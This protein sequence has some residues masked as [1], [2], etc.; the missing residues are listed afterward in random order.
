MTKLSELNEQQ[1]EDVLKVIADQMMNSALEFKETPDRTTFYEVQEFGITYVKA[2][3]YKKYDVDEL[4]HFCTIVNTVAEAEPLVFEDK[5]GRGVRNRL[6]EL[7]DILKKESER[8]CGLYKRT[9]PELSKKIKKELTR[10]YKKSYETQLGRKYDGYYSSADTEAQQMTVEFWKNHLLD[11]V[12]I[13]NDTPSNENLYPIMVCLPEYIDSFFTYISFVH[14]DIFI[15]TLQT[16]INIFGNY[17]LFLEKAADT[18]ID[19]QDIPDRKQLEHEINEKNK[20]ELEELTTITEMKIPK[21]GDKKHLRELREQKKEAQEKLDKLKVKI[22]EEV[23]KVVRKVNNNINAFK[24]LQKKA[25]P[26]TYSTYLYTRVA[27][28]AVKIIANLRYLSWERE[29]DAEQS[30]ARTSARRHLRK[31]IKAVTA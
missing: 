19:S 21:T 1:R 29:L 18:A 30:E 15:K 9:N 28:M 25:Y 8:A 12:E 11:S 3:K 14:T 13:M 26:E 5:Y 7:A 31:Q 24:D 16:H 6:H 23:N 4:R 10:D 2:K 17:S 22:E 27:D 20:D